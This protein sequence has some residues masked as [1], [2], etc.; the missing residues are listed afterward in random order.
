MYGEGRKSA[1]NRLQAPVQ[2]SK[3]EQE[4]IQHLRVTDPRD[5]KKR[6]EETQGGLLEDS[7]RPVLENF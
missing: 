5:D 7:Y 2:I 4:C 6:I 1:F 3:E